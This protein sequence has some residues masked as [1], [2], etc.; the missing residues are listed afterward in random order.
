MTDPHSKS[1]APGTGALLII[2]V[3]AGAA[4]CGA[5]GGRTD[6]SKDPDSGQ[7]APAANPDTSTARMAGGP[8]S[9][10][11]TE[12]RAGAHSE[13]GAGDTMG[14]RGRALMDTTGRTPGR[15]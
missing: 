3:L 5:E 4:A 8:D 9:G 11:D 12:A 7:V 15:P 10:G 2:G 13:A 6:Y 14:A 1:L